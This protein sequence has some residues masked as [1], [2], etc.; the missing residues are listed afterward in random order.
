[1]KEVLLYGLNIFLFLVLVILILLA[2]ISIVA[3]IQTIIER[4]K[5]DV[6]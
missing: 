2:I 1:M 3:I 6:K 4:M 5:N